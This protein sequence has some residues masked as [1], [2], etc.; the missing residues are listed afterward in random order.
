MVRYR[1]G[2]FLLGT[3]VGDTQRDV[4]ITRSHELTLE[5]L[6]LL[7]GT[8]FITVDELAAELYD[9]T[10]GPVL[11]HLEGRVHPDNQLVLILEPHTLAVHDLVPA[12]IDHRLTVG[13]YAL[14]FDLHAV[15]TQ[16]GIELGLDGKEV[17]LED[18]AQ[19]ECRHQCDGVITARNRNPRIVVGGQRSLQAAA[20]FEVV[21][22]LAD[23][24]ALSL[25]TG[26]VEI[27][28]IDGGGLQLILES[29]ALLLGID[30]VDRNL[31]RSRNGREQKGRQ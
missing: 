23:S 8:R 17:L 7:L 24:G 21:A 12:F 20:E 1:N 19:V 14:R 15:I 5:V 16:L 2:E 25:V 29:H 26:Q 18:V 9:R 13:P 22:L 30:L 11:G 28:D 31:S 27:I 10:V 4:E 6:F 3:F